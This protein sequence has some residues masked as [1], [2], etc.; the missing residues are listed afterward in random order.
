M[1]RSRF[2]AGLIG[3]TFLALSLAIVLNRAEL[4][5]MVESLRDDRLLVL[6]AGA[7]IF[8]T[9][10]AIVRSHWLWRGWPAVVTVIGCLGVLGGLV[11]MLAPGLVIDEAD[12]TL[13]LPFA[14]PL[15]ATATAALG[16]FLTF[17][18]YRSP[19]RSETAR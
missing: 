2:L 9:G 13:R 14:L 17:Q 3:P 5:A 10:L 12:A 19:R 1:D 18:G 7:V 8:A 11:R 15:A 6:L 4:P 16:L